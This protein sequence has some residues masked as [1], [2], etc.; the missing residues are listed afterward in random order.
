MTSKATRFWSV[1]F[2]NEETGKLVKLIA[3]APASYEAQRIKDTL[4]EVNPEYGALS[5]EEMERPEHISLWADED[6]QPPPAPKD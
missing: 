2:L 6:T 3:Q 4:E 1:S 5:I